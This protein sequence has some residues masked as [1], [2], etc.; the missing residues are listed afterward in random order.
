MPWLTKNIVRH[1]RKR[2]ATFQ[3]AKR[4]NKPEVHS[5]YKH[6][7]NLVV[8]LMRSYKKFYMQ[9]V[10]VANKKQFWKTVKYMNKKN[11]SIPEL[12]HQDNTAKS[13]L[14]KAEMSSLEL[15]SIP[16]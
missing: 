9:R 16:P 7:R 3:A 8:K 1:I 13:E 12:H 14:E 2:N 6:L 10:N 15:A 11:P 5:K 4:T